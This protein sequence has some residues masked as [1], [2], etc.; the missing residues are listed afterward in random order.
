MQIISQES[1]EPSPCTK[2]WE[3]IHIQSEMKRLASC[4]EHT[5][6]VLGVV[7]MVYTF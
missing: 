7:L 4:T 2:F 6:A 1:R 5:K 3:K